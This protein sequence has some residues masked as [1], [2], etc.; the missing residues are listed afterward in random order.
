MQ[1]HAAVVNHGGVDLAVDG[2]ET[3]QFLTRL[4]CFPGTHRPLSI[5]NSW[6]KHPQELQELRNRRER[7][8]TCAGRTEALRTGPPVRFLRTVFPASNMPGMGWSSDLL[9]M[10]CVSEWMGGGKERQRGSGWR[11]RKNQSVCLR[12]RKER[13]EREKE[14][15]N[16]LEERGRKTRGK[17]LK[18]WRKGKREERKPAAS[19]K[20]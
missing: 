16:E 11:K 2:L 6:Q 8:F 3:S 12:E 1:L 17:G 15:V 18:R 5:G 20:L 13:K 9:V 10:L 19:I 4:G 14:G 7:T